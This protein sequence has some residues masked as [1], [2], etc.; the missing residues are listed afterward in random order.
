M[1]HTSAPG[2]GEGGGEEM[3]R[4]RN[5]NKLTKIHSSPKRLHIKSSTLA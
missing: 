3:Q 5:V 1:I 2:A 4:K